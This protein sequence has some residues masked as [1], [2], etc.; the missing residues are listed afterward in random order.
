[1]GV[2]KGV[3]SLRCGGSGPA[4]PD[5]Y[6]PKLPAGCVPARAYVVRS[7]SS[8]RCEFSDGLSAAD[9]VM[10]RQSCTASPSGRLARS[11]RWSRMS[12]GRAIVR[13]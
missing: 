12:C 2:A 8:A 1:M 13:G 9:L 5:H 3:P 10:G 11:Y 4:S 7:K 6:R